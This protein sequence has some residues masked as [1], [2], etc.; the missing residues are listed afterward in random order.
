MFWTVTYAL[1]SNIVLDSNNVLNSNIVLNSNNVLNSQATTVLT[2]HRCILIDYFNNCN[3]IK[4]KLMRSL[5]M[6]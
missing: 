6:V 5:M 1:K 3:F 2:T 4:H